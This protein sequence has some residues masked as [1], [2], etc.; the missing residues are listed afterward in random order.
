M[1]R[2]IF[3]YCAFVWGGFIAL[4]ILAI[5]ISSIRDRIRGGEG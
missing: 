1:I 5:V 4:A 3:Y 2:F